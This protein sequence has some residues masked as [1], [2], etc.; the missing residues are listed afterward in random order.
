MRYKYH[1]VLLAG[2]YEVINCPFS[3]DTIYLCY[4]FGKILLT[5]QVD[6]ILEA[7]LTVSP[8]RQ[9]LGNLVPTTPPTTSPECIPKQVTQLPTDYI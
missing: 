9:Y 7:V 8:K 5:G 6:C 2:I 1:N 4:V 3:A